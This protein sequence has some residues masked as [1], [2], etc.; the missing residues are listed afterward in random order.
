MGGGL[1][2]WAVVAILA[3]P[4]LD[5][6]WRAARAASYTAF[7]R[8][9][10]IFQYVAWALS[11][12]QVDY[13]DIRD[14]NGPLT[15]VVHWVFLALGGSDAHRFHMLDFVVTGGVFAFAGACLVGL[16]RSGKR[17]PVASAMDLWS[18]RLLWGFASLVVLGGQYLRYLYWDLAQRETFCNWMLLP[19]LGL[20]L[21]AQAP[22][23]PWAPRTTRRAALVIAGA[24]SGIACFGKH[25]YALFIGAQ[26]LAILADGDAPGSR[27]QRLRAYGGGILLGVAACVAYLLVF[28]DIRAFYEIYV[29]DAPAMY[30]YIWPH[31][32]EAILAKP[33]AKHTDIY[34]GLTTL[35]MT[36][37]IALGWMPRRL[38]ALALAPTF[39]LVGVFLQMK[40]FPYHFHAYSAPL[41][42]AWLA[43]IAWAAERVTS[44]RAGRWLAAGAA[45]AGAA[46]ITMLVTRAMPAS[47]HI[48]NPWPPE[49]GHTAEMRRERAY[50]DRF[51]MYDFFPYETELAAGY[52]R[53]HTLPAD[54]VQ[55][56]GMDPYV[57]FLAERL[58][59]TPYIY[60]YDLDSDAATSGAQELLDEPEASVAVARID[61]MISAHWRDFMTRVES[62]PPAAFVFFDKAPLVSWPDAFEDF[63][64]HNAAA[65]AWVRGR[66]VRAADFGEV[67]VWL[68]ADLAP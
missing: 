13:R 37:L 43:T 27:V 66:Y 22:A 7:G 26:V 16:S 36:S 1:F 60:A 6:T 21:W 65:A 3:L 58:S 33:W 20:C 64:K 50:L 32:R 35:G 44:A 68:R 47:P 10:G 23:A 17:A 63:E 31:T 8:D 14:V 39:G 49:V 4:P 2:T 11:R 51:K 38:L 54:R 48:Q 28:G 12:G 67:H 62:A 61:A 41:Y 46:T 42:L 25:T 15:H 40:G 55:I 29:N 56:Y 30:R 57:M 19:S 5:I 9:Q 18:E 45:L 53:A 52:I 24:L 34:A 59:A